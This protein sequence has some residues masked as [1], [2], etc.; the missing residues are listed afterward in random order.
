MAYGASDET[1]REG[2]RDDI[3][4]LQGRAGTAF[5]PRNRCIRNNSQYLKAVAQHILTVI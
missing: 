4:P 2:K 1:T 5:Q 3:P